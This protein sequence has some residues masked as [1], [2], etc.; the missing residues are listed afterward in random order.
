M[1]RRSA[2]QTDRWLAQI[3][4]EERGPDDLN[5]VFPLQFPR[6]IFS[7]VRRGTA[8]KETETM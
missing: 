4:A 2:T 7:I 6:I 1:H 5:L 8:T 3:A